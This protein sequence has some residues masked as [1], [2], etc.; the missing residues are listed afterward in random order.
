MSDDL[1]EQLRRQSVAARLPCADCRHMRDPHPNLAMMHYVA[2]EW[3]PPPVAL[4]ARVSMQE[5]NP[6]PRKGVFGPFTEN[7]GMLRC[8]TFGA[9]HE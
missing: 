1:L 2:C 5:H 7:P 6:Q 9:R 3:T 8:P 4:G